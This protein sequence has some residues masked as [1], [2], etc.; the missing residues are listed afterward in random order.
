V[1][2]ASVDT[3]SDSPSLDDSDWESY[4]DE[5][6]AMLLLLVAVH[7]LHDEANHKW[8]RQGSTIRWLCIPQNRAM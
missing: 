6:E 8:K 4:N 2:S 1:W 7:S 3:C 5:I